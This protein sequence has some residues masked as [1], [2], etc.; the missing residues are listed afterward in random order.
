[1][2]NEQNFVYV[3][4]CMY[5]IHVCKLKETITITFYKYGKTWQIGI[6]VGTVH[7]GHDMINS[8]GQIN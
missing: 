3:C 8:M 1:M 2:C 4:V 5:V 6:A 7:D